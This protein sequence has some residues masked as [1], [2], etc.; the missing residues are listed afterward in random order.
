MSLIKTSFFKCSIKNFRD[1]F[2]MDGQKEAGS[3][4]ILCPITHAF[5]I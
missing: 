3:T 1:R 4:S 2:F 5:M